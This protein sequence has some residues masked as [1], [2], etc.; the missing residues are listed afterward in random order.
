MIKSF[1]IRDNLENT[2]CSRI[3]RK[4]QING[5]LQK[6]QR[7]YFFLRNQKMQAYFDQ[8]SLIQNPE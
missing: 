8:N 1:H 3:N 5:K 7:F 4:V 2:S 6:K